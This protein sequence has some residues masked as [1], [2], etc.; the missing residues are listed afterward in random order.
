M[1]D[2]VAARN[3]AGRLLRWA[4]AIILVVLMVPYLL[5]PLY[6]LVRPVSTPMLWRWATGAPVERTWVPL[7]AIDKSLV[8]SVLMS[9]DG[10]FCS[11]H[12]VDWAELNKVISDDEGPSRGASTIAMQ[13]VKNLFLWTSRS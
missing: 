9:E 13:T 4:I 11:H 6:L 3:P 10:K 12:G 1:S 5:T 7:E 2:K 8:A